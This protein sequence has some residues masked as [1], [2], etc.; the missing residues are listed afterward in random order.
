MISKPPSSD[1]MMLRQYLLGH[2]RE[3]EQRALEQRLLTDEDY[4]HQLLRVEEELTDDYVRG[5]LDASDHQRFERYFLSSPERRQNVEFA[6]AFHRYL[7]AQAQRT[8]PHPAVFSGWRAMGEIALL[9]AVIVLAALAVLLFHRN[10]QLQKLVEQDRI[11]HSQADQRE[12]ELSDRLE[13]EQKQSDELKQDLASLQNSTHPTG[14]DLVSLVLTPGISRADDQTA[15]VDVRPGIHR[16]RLELKTEDVGHQ[17]YRA[18]LQNMEG[19]VVWSNDN[20]KARGT[21]DK[22]FVE[23][24]L[25][26]GLITRSDYL[27][28]LSGTNPSGS[29]EKISTYHFSVIRK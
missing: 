19:D 9:C 6:R 7:A 16:L 28:A 5:S 24:I 4:F 25:A 29:F 21:G 8:S 10:T 12:K 17:S 20:L 18:E 13:Q 26:T 27:V 1:E 14:S 22:R 15:T 11:Q 2:V 23:F 3:D